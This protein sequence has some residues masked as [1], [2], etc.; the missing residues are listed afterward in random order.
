MWKA[1]TPTSVSR[2]LNIYDMWRGDMTFVSQ[3]SSPVEPLH[4]LDVEL[5]SFST[6]QFTKSLRF[7]WCH[8]HLEN[9]LSKCIFHY[10]AACHDVNIY[11][12]RQHRFT[13]LIAASR[14]GPFMRSL[15]LPLGRWFASSLKEVKL[16][17]LID[18]LPKSNHLLE[19]YT[20]VSRGQ[21]A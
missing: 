7:C 8:L 2:I 18:L 9:H 11:T 20:Q 12:Q 16:A 19:E 15:I 3:L 5:T 1:T 6:S 14:I 21:K 4:E 13:R 17:R 10:E